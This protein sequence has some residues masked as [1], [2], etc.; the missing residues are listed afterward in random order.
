MIGLLKPGHLEDKVVVECAPL[1]DLDL[2]GRARTSNLPHS[3]IVQSVAA[4]MSMPCLAYT[5]CA[6][7]CACNSH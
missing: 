2:L 7:C 4:R 1:V 6:S 5:L 3:R